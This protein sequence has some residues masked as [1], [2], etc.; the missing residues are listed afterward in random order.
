MGK[1]RTGGWPRK[2]IRIPTCHVFLVAH[3]RGKVP[4]RPDDRTRYVGFYELIY[5]A[6]M[7]TVTYMLGQTPVRSGVMLAQ[8]STI[9]QTVFYGLAYKLAHVKNLALVWR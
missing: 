2:T 3:R 6:S 7:H 8:T 4:A 5:F 9:S 1:E